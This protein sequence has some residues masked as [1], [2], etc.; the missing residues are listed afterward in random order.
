M[1]NKK[2]MAGLLVCSIAFSILPGS[3]LGEEGAAWEQT[4][5]TEAFSEGTVSWNEQEGETAGSV[6]GPDG[7]TEQQPGQPEFTGAQTE[8]GS[9][10]QVWIQEE[11]Y[12]EY[13]PEEGHGPGRDE[14]ERGEFF[15]EE[16]VGE[17]DI[18]G[19]VSK[20]TDKVYSI[21]D[22]EIQGKEEAAE[23]FNLPSYTDLYAAMTLEVP[24]ILQNPEL[25]TGC[26]SVALT[27]ALRYE[28]FDIGKTTI[29]EDFLIYNRE[30]DNV[31]TGYVGDPFSEE[32]AGCFAP[33]IAATA[34]GF[35]EDQGADYTAYDITDSDFEE[36]LGYVA[37]GTPVIV[38]TTMYMA[39]PEFTREDSEYNGHVYRWYRQEHC[40]VLSGYDLN[41]NTVQINDPLEGIVTRD[42]DEFAHIYNQT[43]KNAV[44]LKSVEQVMS[45]V[46]AG[47]DT[48]NTE[49][50]LW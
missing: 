2:M 8:A 42:M 15:E 38:W 18:T 7:E 43:G 37:K 23:A 39:E 34:L 21:E 17:T 47:S 25:P 46:S 13:G 32:G 41:Q 26:E 28:G 24:E 11:N 16:Y 48:Q 27:M 35:F 22:F 4:N 49:V 50:G 14:Y 36:L 45:A 3:V 19:S 33:A 40:V 29:A 30:S 20:L 44:V 12:Q 6:Q 1:N 9:W 5:S 31:A 10:E